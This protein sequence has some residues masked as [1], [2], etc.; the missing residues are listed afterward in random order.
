[1]NRTTTGQ[2]GCALIG[3]GNFGRGLARALQEDARVRFAGVLVNPFSALISSLRPAPIWLSAPSY[4][5][6][7]MQR[8]ASPRHSSPA[9]KVTFQP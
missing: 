1:M 5:R 6:L 7:S 9:K 3:P 2:L 8:S 4:A